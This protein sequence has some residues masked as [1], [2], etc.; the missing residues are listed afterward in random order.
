MKLNNLTIILFLLGTLELIASFIWFS[1]CFDLSQFILY[2]GFGFLLLIF[3]Y[4]YE[5]M[6]RFQ[7]QVKEQEKVINAFDLWVRQEFKK[8]NT[9]LNKQ[10]DKK[11]KWNTKMN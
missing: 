10:E 7:N 1:K 8:L 2:L 5:W 3:A 11:L 9:Q 4:I 6:K